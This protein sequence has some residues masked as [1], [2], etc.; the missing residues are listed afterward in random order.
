MMHPPNYDAESIS[1]IQE[2]C[3]DIH[4]SHIAQVNTVEP[5]IFRYKAGVGLVVHSSTH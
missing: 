1:T 4:V 2:R 3:L 5:R